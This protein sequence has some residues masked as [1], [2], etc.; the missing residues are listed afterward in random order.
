MLVLEGCDLAGKTTLQ[1]KVWD[2]LPAYIPLHLTKPK[3]EFS[4]WAYI[5]LASPHV[6]WDR[7]HISELAY[8][9]LDGQPSRILDPKGL[10]R[11]LRKY[12]GMVC[13]HVTCTPETLRSRF[14]A[15]GDHLY[16]LEEIERVRIAYNNLAWKGHFDLIFS[17]DKYDQLDVEAL[18]RAYRECKS[19]FL[20]SAD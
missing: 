14:E 13:V 9:Q 16:T 1:H 18:V 2:L 11:S 8:R 15:R 10:Q 4:D 19:R 3:D 7:Y 20:N 12:F 6:I 17:T 5:T